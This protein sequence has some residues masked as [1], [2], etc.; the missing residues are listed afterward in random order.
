MRERVQEAY[1]KVKADPGN[2]ETHG[3]LGMILHALENRTALECYKQALLL[4]PVTPPPQ[5]T[6]S[7]EDVVH[8]LEMGLLPGRSTAGPGQRP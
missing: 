4:E 8:S 6:V 7:A 1:E 5:R 3:R 2:P